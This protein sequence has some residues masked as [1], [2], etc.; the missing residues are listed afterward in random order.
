MKRPEDVT[1]SREEG[2]ALLA[3]LEATTLTTEDR[4]VLGQVLTFYFWL[5]FALREAKLSLKR[6]KTV[7]V[8]EKPTKRE[9]PSSGGTPSGGS[10]GGTSTQTAASQG[11]DEAA[12]PE[13]S[14]GKQRPA[15][16]G[17]HGA[18]VYRAAQTVECRHDELAVGERR[19]C[20]YYRGRR[21]AGEN[22]DA[23]LTK[24]EPQRENPVVLSDALSSN[25]AEETPLLRCHC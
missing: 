21:Q 14:E 18:E 11:R 3:R 24:R 4:R 13:P 20:L 16:H 10:R 25:K 17:R 23:L 19:L 1:L 2:E 5:L 7:V 15:G 12:A 9:P 8:G 6:L 22:L